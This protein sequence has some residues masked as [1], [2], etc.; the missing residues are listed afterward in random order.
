MRDNPA[1]I[2][3]SFSTRQPTNLRPSPLGLIRQ[4]CPEVNKDQHTARYPAL[5]HY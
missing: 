2:A 1:G 4:S 3:F 5:Y